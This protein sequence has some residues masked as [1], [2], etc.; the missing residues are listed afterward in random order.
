MMTQNLRRWTYLL[1]FVGWTSPMAA[2]T[3]DTGVTIRDARRIL[4]LGD[5]ITYAGGYVTLLQLAINDGDPAPSL[6]V[7]GGLPSETLSGLSEPNH[8]DGRFARPVLFERLDRMLALVQP[9]VVLACYG[10]ND[11][12]YQPLDSVRTEAFQTGTRRLAEAVRAAGATL[13]WITPPI[14]DGLIARQNNFDGDANY[15]SVLAAYAKL[16]TREFGS[17]GLV[18]DLHTAMSRELKRRRRS[19]PEFSFQNDAV[20]PGD[21]GHRLI[22]ETVLDGLNRAAGTAWQLPP[23]DDPRIPGA[24]AAMRRTRDAALTTA[25]HR[26]PGLPVGDDF[27]A[28]LPPQS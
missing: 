3:G 18:I 24:T 25:G 11:G 4:I 9:D 23:P 15:D 16:Q 28:L 12:I 21:E 13:I 14:F 17:E 8:A 20:H 26:R 1:L 7:N 27:R 22:A 2:Q 5:S 6:I 19:D 10:M